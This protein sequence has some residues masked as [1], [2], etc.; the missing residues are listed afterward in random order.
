MWRFRGSG[1][2][3]PLAGVFIAL[4]GIDGSG[5]STMAERLV[6]AFRTAGMPAVL[7][8]EPGGTTLGERIRSVLLSDESVT[9]LP[10]AEALL[11]AAARA[12]LVG[13]VIR[14]AL[15]RG[16]IVIT[17]RFTDSSLA[18]QWGGR[19]LD[20][21]AVRAV[22]KMATAELEPDI[23]ILLDLPVETALRRRLSNADAVNRL[24]KEAL[25]F[26]ARVRDAYHSLAEGDPPRWR[27]IDAARSEDLVWCDVSR[28]VNLSELASESAAWMRQESKQKVIQ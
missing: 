5:K 18:Y 16:T 8:R 17:D 20:K 15:E 1:W 2:V 24:D 23:K 27:I 11:F 21:D 19:E 9:M 10:E 26:H 4:E 13:E 7:T 12:Q 22:Q 6:H 14:P 3:D 28:A 25:E